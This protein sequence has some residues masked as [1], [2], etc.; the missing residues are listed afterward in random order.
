MKT[1]SGIA[2]V[3]SLT[4]EGGLSVYLAQI[5]KFPILDA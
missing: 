5:K 3:P 4:S 2:N 1:K